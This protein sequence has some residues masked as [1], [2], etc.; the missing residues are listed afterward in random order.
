MSGRAFTLAT[1]LVC[2]SLVG[3]ALW[4][5]SKDTARIRDFWGSHG[6]ELI[7]RAAH[8]ELCCSEPAKE[9]DE[10]GDCR[11]TDIS[12]APGLVHL[13]ATLVEDR[14]FQWPARPVKDIPQILN[15]ASQA[16]KD[17]AQAQ[18]AP[19]QDTDSKVAI[20]HLCKLR[21]EG[22]DREPMELSI[23]LGSGTVVNLQ[24]QRSVVLIDA[25][26]QAVAAYIQALEQDYPAG[27]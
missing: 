8:V 13:R 1:L 9:G 15:E 2:L 21:F 5:R 6:A 7:Q 23:D 27:K 20:D 14:Y 19:S 17:V 16:Q 4:Q 12:L 18:V 10:S 25:S 26:R 24:T 11:W 22:D 3:F